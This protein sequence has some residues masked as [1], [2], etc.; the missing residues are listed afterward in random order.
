VTDKALAT[1]EKTLKR[2]VQKKKIT[3]DQAVDTREHLTLLKDIDGFADCDLIIEAV[4]EETA[5]KK[6]IF[7]TLDRFQQEETILAS[8]TS[9]FSITDLSA[10][11]QRRDRFIGLH[12]F[13]PATIMKLVEIV[14]TPITDPDVL[15]MAH[16]FI[17]SIGKEPLLTRDR[18]GFIVNALLA[19]LLYDAMRAMEQG[20]GSTED[21]DKA[22]EL[23]CGHPVGP[24][25]LAD[26]IGLDILLNSTLFEEFKEKRYA[27]PPIIHRLVALGFLGRKTGRGFYDWSDPK[28]PV[29]VDYD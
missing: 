11:L 2:L 4:V 20:V 21:I 6:K 28:K 24:L 12:F 14:K 26:L 5:V 15:A 27:P 3:A 16:Q 10:D 19:P 23:G 1:I 9:S 7:T 8:N 13:N 25:K 29:P 18:G 22:M 17:V